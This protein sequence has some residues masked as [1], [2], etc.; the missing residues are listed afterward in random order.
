MQD[1]DKNIEEYNPQKK[2]KV[3]IAFDDIA[4]YLWELTAVASGR[5]SVRSLVF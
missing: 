5:V 3:L 1:V 4:W 2:L